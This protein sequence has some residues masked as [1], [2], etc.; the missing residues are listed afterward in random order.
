MG[1]QNF[2]LT[3]VQACSSGRLP[4][5]E[6]GPMWH[7]AVIAVCLVL[8]IMLLVALRLRPRAQAQ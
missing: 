3:Y 1:D 5:S 8:A 4:Y 7:L 2:L 6:C